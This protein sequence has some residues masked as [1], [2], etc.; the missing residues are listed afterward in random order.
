MFDICAHALILVD[1]EIVQNGY[2][3]LCEQFFCKIE[4][5]SGLTSFHNIHCDQLMAIF[6]LNLYYERIRTDEFIL[7]TVLAWSND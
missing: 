7:F 3:S 5:T 6:L 4:T 1:K 2:L